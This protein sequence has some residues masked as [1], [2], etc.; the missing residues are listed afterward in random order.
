MLDRLQQRL[1]LVLTPAH[2]YLVKSFAW[3]R[4]SGS[5]LGT[6]QV[7]Q[8]T[9]PSFTHLEGALEQAMKAAA[10]HA[11]GVQV[12]LSDP[13]T[14][15]WL[16]DVPAK[17]TQCKDLEAAAAMR[18]Q[19]LFDESST[20]WEISCSFE[21]QGSFMACAVPRPL[22]QLLTHVTHRH[23]MTA[24]SMQPEFVAVWNKWCVHIKPGEWLVM[25]RPQSVSLVVANAR[26]IA[27]VRQIRWLPA[28]AL[29][30]DWLQ[31]QAKQEA[32]RLH[33]PLPTRLHVCG[34]HPSTW[35]KSTADAI[36]CHILGAQSDAMSLLGVQA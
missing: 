16:V 31:Q 5:L 10:A 34:K 22:H 21:S 30:A 12:Y 17:A 33:A 4:S 2:V 18:F 7:S 13:L 32:L 9:A 1:C 14:R 27:A 20:D 15:W 25:L 36:P 8:D 35:L 6:W 28:F 19:Q 29:E 11:S 26:G 24:V 23:R 3:P